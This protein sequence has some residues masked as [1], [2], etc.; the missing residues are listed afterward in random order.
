M[1][2]VTVYDKQQKNQIMEAAQGETLM[3]LLGR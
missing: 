1:I 2:R 3:Q